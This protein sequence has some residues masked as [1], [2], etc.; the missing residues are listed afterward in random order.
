[1]RRNISRGF[2]PRE[3]RL[4]SRL[5]LDAMIRRADF[6][7]KSGSKGDEHQASA[8]PA[9]SITFENLNSSSNFVLSLR[10]PDFQRETNQ[11]SSNQA[12]TFIQSFIDGDLVPSVIL[13]QS[14]DG[15]IFAIDGAHRL[16]ALRAWIEDDYGDRGIS[17]SFFGGEI[18]SEQKRTALAM[19]REI[20]KRV[21]SYQSLRDKL[22]ARAQ[23]PDIEYDPLTSKRLRHIGSRQLELQWVTGDAEVAEA[24]FFKINT[25]G[26]PLDKTEELLLRNRKRAPAIAARSIVRAAT[27]H[28]YWS[29]FS[30]DVR[31]K[32]EDLSSRVNYLL[33]RPELETPLKTLQLPLGG[34]GSNLDALALLIRLLSITEGTQQNRKPRINDSPHDETGE[35]TLLALK[36]CISIVERITGNSAGSLGLHPAVYFYSDRGTYLPDFLLGIAYLIKGKILNGDDLF[37]KRFTRNRSTIEQFLV[38]NKAILSQV[39]LQVSSRS[40]TERLSDIIDYMVREAENG[41]TI[42]GVADAAKLKGSIVS[43]REKVDGKVF[44]R[45]TKSAILIRQSLQSPLRCPICCG[46]MEPALSASYDH[47]VRKEDGGTGDDENGQLSH[48]YCNTGYKN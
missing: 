7:Q 15:L 3:V 37:F 14:Q 22:T 45:D 33:F 16:S 5:V 44:S 11:W 12:A 6:W 28:K 41:L 8:R 48:P 19:R 21:G 27:G 1:M 10:K 40:R 20:E 13:W 42:E 34:S 17:L 23:N 47:I 31:E 24:S 38:D 39:M 46:F 35:L 32:I 43:L 26:T 29:M 36:N 4:A 30:S 9:T 25:Q 18:P 2:A